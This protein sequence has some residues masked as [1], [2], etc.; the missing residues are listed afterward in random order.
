[1]QDQ[2]YD[3]AGYR[4]LA[5]AIIIQ[6]LRDLGGAE[7]SGFHTG[8]QRDSV[9]TFLFSTSFDEM[10]VLAGWECDWLLDVFKSIDRLGD[11][12]KVRITREAVELIRGLP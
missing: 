6:S 4:R 11:G 5:R 3:A 12:V 10:C 2:N 7:I 1:M 8:P 9:L